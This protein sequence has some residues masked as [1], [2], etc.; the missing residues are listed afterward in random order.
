MATQ[1]TSAMAACRRTAKLLDRTI[2]A[3]DPRV[4][5][6]QP[7]RAIVQQY[8]A[9]LRRALSVTPPL[10]RELRTSRPIR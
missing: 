5:Y 8:F 9:Q 7:N 10:L 6:A 4:A 3:A 1:L 2:P